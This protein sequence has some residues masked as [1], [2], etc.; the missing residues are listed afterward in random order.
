MKLLSEILVATDFSSA[1]ESAVETAAYVAKLFGSPLHLLHV[2]SKKA[3]SPEAD[4]SQD[5]EQAIS[6]QLEEM[7][8]KLE[9][10]G[11]PGV[12][13]IALSGLAFA[14]ID[15]YAREQDVNVIIV[16]A[17]ETGSSGQVYL[18]TTAARL[19]RKSSKPVWIV[20]PDVKTPIKRVL[21]P[22]DFSNASARALKNAV[23]LARKFQAEL[24]VLTVIQPF[25]REY[26]RLLNSKSASPAKHAPRSPELDELVADCDIHEVVLHKLV[27]RG[28][29]REVIVEVAAELNA[30]LI[31]MGSVGRTGISHMLVGGV[32]RRV[33]QEMPCSIITVRSEEPIQLKIDGKVR[34]VDANFCAGRK[35]GMR[36]DRL[37]HGKK[38]LEE[39]FADRAAVHFGECL[40]EYD[41][42]PHAWQ[43]LGKAKARQGDDIGAEKCEARS[44]ELADIILNQEVEADLRENHPLF[45]SIFGI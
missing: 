7:A 3:D 30:E 19:R 24:T 42:C 22:V 1:A 17:G 8:R 13:P 11:V 32:A 6:S 4:P 5:I 40:D 29:P 45:R 38:L 16:G 34:E 36:C 14:Q 43:C 25:S 37:E 12:K 35:R 10:E 18:G 21:C 31:V 27:R 2:R 44:K 9:Q 39:G 20:R 28:K 15:R 33:A 41:L 26:E 23:H